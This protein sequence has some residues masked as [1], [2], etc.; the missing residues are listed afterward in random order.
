MRKLLLLLPIV[1]FTSC[2][3]QGPQYAEYGRLVDYSGYDMFISEAT[4]VSF[5]YEPLGSVVANVESGYNKKE[6]WEAKPEDALRVLVRE[7]SR[8]GANGIINVK[9]EYHK[10]WYNDYKSFR[11]SYT[12][13]GM[14]IRK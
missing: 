12:A 4:S 14:A 2:M 13:T 10:I 1:F 6:Y 11:G 8:K 9:I 7:A 3:I 5:E